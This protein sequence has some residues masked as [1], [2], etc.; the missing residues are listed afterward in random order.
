MSYASLAEFLEDLERERLLVRIEAEVSPDLEIAEIS[1]RNVECQG[2]ALLFSRLK[3]QRL[4]VVTNLLATENRICRALGVDSLAAMA[5]RLAESPTAATGGGWIDAL[6]LFPAGNGGSRL[7][8]RLVKNAP[9]QQVV[10]LAS[11]VDLGEL[12]FLPRI[13]ED[14]T[15]CVLAA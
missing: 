10:R 2:P 7:E 15:G 9:S 11:D 3:G 6:R 1:R 5:Q 4:P 14:Y 8:P 13:S 12:P